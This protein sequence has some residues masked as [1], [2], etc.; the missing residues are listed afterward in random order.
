[1]TAYLLPTADSRPKRCSERAPLA[2]NDAD[3]TRLV[4]TRPRPD[5]R[6]RVRR[7]E[8]VLEPLDVLWGEA[9][10]GAPPSKVD[11]GSEA[12]SVI[13]DRLLVDLKDPRDCALISFA[14][15]AKCAGRAPSARGKR[16]EL[17]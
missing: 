3:I 9:V 13:G 5:P 11:A 2:Q 16:V 15:R 8:F 7:F 10:A 4:Q 6:N 17:R 12:T 14:P 1:L